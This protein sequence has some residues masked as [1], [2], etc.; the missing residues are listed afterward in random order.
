MSQ[1]RKTEYITTVDK[2]GKYL[3][4][5]ER[6]ECHQGKGILHSAFLVMIFNEHTEL[7]LAKRSQYKN[8]W[9]DFW[10]GTVASHYH[11]EKDQETA[12]KERILHEIGVSCDQVNYLFKFQYQV[13][14]KDIGS[15]NEICDVFVAKDIKN[16]QISINK[17]EISEIKFLSIP[18]LKGEIQTNSNKY[19]P[20]FLIA[21]KKYFY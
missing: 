13:E 17:M 18:E 6:E 14:Y 4:I 2:N 16:G 11:S 19:T 8:L 15:E 5:K 7:I 3:G 1:S 9:P 21:L 12:I 20:W 10:D